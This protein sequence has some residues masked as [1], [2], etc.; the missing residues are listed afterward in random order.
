M[1][2]K[3]K[4]VGHNTKRRVGKAPGEMCGKKGLWSINMMHNSKH[5]WDDGIGNYYQLF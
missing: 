1:V 4:K 2:K 3:K 5:Q